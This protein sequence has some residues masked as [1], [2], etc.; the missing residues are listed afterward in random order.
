MES[1][2]ERRRVGNGNLPR[3]LTA[4]ERRA[5]YAEHRDAPVRIERIL[6]EL[7]R[8]DPPMEILSDDDSVERG[9]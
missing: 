1:P 7:N 6:Y 4:A 5:W 2:R 3:G 9:A 8:L